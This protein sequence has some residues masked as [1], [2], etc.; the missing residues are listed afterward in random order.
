MSLDAPRRRS[1]F[2][3]FAPFVLLALVIVGWTAAWFVIRGEVEKRLDARLAAEAAAGRRWECPERAV[4]GFPFRIEVRCAR[5]AFA[6]PAL[7]FTAGPLRTVTQVYQPRH[8]IV[9]FD[10]PLRLTAGEAVTEATWSDLK[11]SLQLKSGGFERVSLAAE[12]VSLRVTGLPAGEVAG[13][14]RRFEAHLRPDPARPAADN[15]VEVAA[16]LSGAAVPLLNLVL[17]GA[18]TVDAELRAGVTQARP[19]RGTLRDRVEG[20]RE[21][22]GR[23]AIAS[24]TASQGPRRIEASGDLGLDA[25]HRPAGHLDLAAAGIADLLTQLVGPLPGGGA[26]EA[27]QG[28]LPGMGRRETPADPKLR[29]LPRLTFADGRLHVGPLPVPRV[30]LQPLY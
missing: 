14:A 18:E 29:R 16:T 17:G 25:L 27:L 24:F 21:A 11:A 3:L 23:L 9:D 4:G 22:G 13:T 19:G 12:G 8:T 28:R 20:W 6:G 30:R 15:A 10:G 7:A 1:R 5:V 2:W 26:F